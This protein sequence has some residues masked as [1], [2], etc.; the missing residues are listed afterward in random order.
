MSKSETNFKNMTWY[1]LNATGGPY[2]SYT[3]YGSGNKSK[4]FTSMPYGHY[5]YYVKAYDNA[6]NS[7]TTPTKDI[8][9]YKSSTNF[10][11]GSTNFS[12]QT[13]ATMEDLNITLNNTWAK[14]LFFSANLTDSSLD[15]DT[16]VDFSDSVV[17][18]D[19]DKMKAFKNIVATITMNGIYFA[20][21]PIIK[22][23]GAP[24]DSCSDINY[25]STSGNLTFNVT[26][27]S[28]YTIHPPAGGITGSGSSGGGGGSYSQNT[29]CGNGIC[30]AWRGETKETCTADCRSPYSVTTSSSSSTNGGIVATSGTY[31]TSDSD[32]DG[33]PDYM[34][35]QYYLTNPGSKDSD[36]DGVE[37][38]AEVADSSTPG[39]IRNPQLNQ[40]LNQ[41]MLPVDNGGFSWWL[42]PVAAIV[43]L[44]LV[45]GVTKRNQ[46]FGLLKKRY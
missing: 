40:Q 16:Y 12:A 24:C 15:F 38:S 5:K 3:Y 44:L 46:I 29:Y 21:T 18:I 33:L 11:Y 10:A 32:R 43:I 2:A 39:Q 35:I 20:S 42:I 9:L 27:F 8:F 6:T 26:G 17:D 4:N 1:I 36:K 7:N 22:K 13:N 41:I 28:I 31:K 25:N 45:L 14:V 37:D 23:D 30:E 34:E 19:I